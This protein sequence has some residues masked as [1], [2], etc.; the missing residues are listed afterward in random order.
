MVIRCSHVARK[1][2]FLSLH[3][4]LNRS[5]IYQ[6]ISLRFVRSGNKICI[7]S[8]KKGKA[9]KQRRVQFNRLEKDRER[10]E[11]HKRR[12]ENKIDQ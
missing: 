1:G 7:L 8:K 12:I 10:V 2:S 6:Y 3:T 9:I 5:Y 11:I 4:R